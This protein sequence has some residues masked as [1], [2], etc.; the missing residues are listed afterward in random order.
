[1]ARSGEPDEKAGFTRIEL[2]VVVI[3]IA[4]LTGM[5]LPH[6]IGWLAGSTDVLGELLF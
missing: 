2:M 4:A 3:I 1:M 6:V 5:V